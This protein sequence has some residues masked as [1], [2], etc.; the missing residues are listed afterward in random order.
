M[1][2]YGSKQLAASFRTVRGNTIRVA[3]DLP[4]EHYGFRAAPDVHSVAEMLA[5]IALAPR[6][7]EQVHFVEHRNSMVG[8]DFFDFRDRRIADEALRRDKAAVVELLRSEGERF[9]QLLD[10][11][12]DEFLAEFVEFPQGVNPP[13][14]RFEMLL[15]AKEHEM[16]H[17]GQLMLIERI[18]G[19]TP[20]LTRQMEE[21]IAAMRAAKAAG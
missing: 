12:A 17:R 9:A 18:L 6:F 13:K 16:H 3:E 21:R 8:F 2:C 5:H 19:I 10:G 7:Q 20:H 14:S 15:S 11:A 1:T 4:E